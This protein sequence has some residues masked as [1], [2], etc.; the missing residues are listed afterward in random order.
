MLTNYFFN[1]LTFQRIVLN[2][3][4]N[5][6]VKEFFTEVYLGDACDYVKNTNIDSFPLY[7]PACDNLKNLG[8]KRVILFLN[9]TFSVLVN[10][11]L[12]T[13]QQWKEAFVTISIAKEPEWF[14]P[15]QAACSY[16]KN[17]PSSYKP[18]LVRC[19]LKLPN[20]IDMSKMYF[21]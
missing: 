10:F 18:N 9:Q 15:E 5:E 1:L 17:I 11:L 4:Q 13:I 3:D 16:D 19:L 2:Y 7:E 12:Q 6:R 21:N 8:Y 20:M 14:Y